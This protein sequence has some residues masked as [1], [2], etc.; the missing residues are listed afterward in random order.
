MSAGRGDTVGAVQ[1]GHE[2]SSRERSNGLT[3]RPSA[4]STAPRSNGC[5]RSR[6]SATS[7]PASL[8]AS[9][10]DGDGRCLVS[11]RH[12]SAGRSSAG[13]AQFRLAAERTE[14][15]SLGTHPETPERGD[16]STR[17]RRGGAAVAAQAQYVLNLMGVE[18]APF[19]LS[20]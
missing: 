6:P 10:R 12:E 13:L 14:G 11:A 7:F 2:Q 18:L 4:D 17:M 3:R 16:A 9:A 19:R 8:S 15:R 20:L 5:R 1:A